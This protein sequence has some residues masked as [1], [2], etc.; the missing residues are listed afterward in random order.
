MTN[1]EYIKKGIE[2]IYEKSPNVHLDVSFKHPKLQLEHDSVKIIGA[3][4]NLF[5]IE[6][7]SSV[8]AQCHSLQYADV[9]AGH[10]KIHELK[11]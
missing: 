5:R 11:M 9:L 1:I 7:Y 4:A 3:Y 2:R 10:I 8:T 6:E